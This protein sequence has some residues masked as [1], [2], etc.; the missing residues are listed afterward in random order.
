[1]GLFGFG[2]SYSKED[3]DKEIAKLRTLYIEAMT[4]PSPKLK[5][6][7]AQQ[8]DE[9][10]KV[11]EKGGFKGWETVEWPTP[12]TYTSLRNVTPPVQVLVELI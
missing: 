10:M 2:K 11:C 8:I 9:V 7:L 12:G 5:R 4:A 3:L 1:M 6:D